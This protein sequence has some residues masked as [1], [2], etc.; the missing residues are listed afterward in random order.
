MKKKSLLAYCEHLTRQH[1]KHKKKSGNTFFASEC[2]TKYK[3]YLSIK[4]LD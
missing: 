4:R 3:M 2:K 1:G